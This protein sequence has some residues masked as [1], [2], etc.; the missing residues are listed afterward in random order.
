MKRLQILPSDGDFDFPKDRTGASDFVARDIA[1]DV[2]ITGFV[3][4]GGIRRFDVLDRTYEEGIAACSFCVILENRQRL[5]W[6]RLIYTNPVNLNSP[7]EERLN[8]LVI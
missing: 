3:G 8:R 4:G 2:L 1:Q 7:F 5:V 6:E